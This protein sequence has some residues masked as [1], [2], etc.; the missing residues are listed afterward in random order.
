MIDWRLVK[1]I[2]GSLSGEAPGVEFATGGLGPLARDAAQRIT[3]YTGL[4]PRSSL[5]APELVS[6]RGWIDAN[7]ETM[8]PVF[9]ELAGRLPNRGLAAG[10]LGP[11]AN[12][13]SSAVLSA[14]VGAMTGYLAQRVLGQ[15]DIPLL[16]ASGAARLLLV[17]PN[18]VATAERMQADR[19]D[20]LRWVTL[21]EVTHAAQF[22]AVD[23]LR[24]FLARG[25]GGL[26][27]SLELQV[28]APP[29][30]RIP[31]AADLRQL[32]ESARS[33]EL[34]TFVIGRERRALV[35]QLQG[36]MAIVEGHA[37]HVMDVIGEE[38]I[39]SQAQLRAGLEQ[40]RAT[41]ST[42]LRLIERLLGIELKMRQ[43]REGKQFCDF[44]VGRGGIAALD[45]VWADEHALP[46]RAELLEPA[47]W[48]ARTAMPEAH[49]ATS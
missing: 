39:P 3:A 19:D 6:R 10:P 15:Y 44:V 12:Q 21:H 28:A 9:D 26:L 42:P 35:D 1:R 24:P 48:L 36:A 37:E 11:L 32:F 27:D 43:Y 29:S 22:G 5:P 46:S 17:V 13:A 8:R 40:R 7:I 47:L 34:V 18:L 33:G 2:A 20:L 23:W 49:G 16:D 25:L 31:S 14:Q 45:R 30:M 38:I 41:R 4:E